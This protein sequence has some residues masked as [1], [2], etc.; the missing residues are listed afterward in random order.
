MAVMS[1]ASPWWYVC[2]AVGGWRH[3]RL[4]ITLSCVE[5]VVDDVHVR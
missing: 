1:R 5:N 2:I 4:Q 3:E